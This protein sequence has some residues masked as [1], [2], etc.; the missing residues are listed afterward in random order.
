MA[1]VIPKDSC[2][3]PLVQQKYCCVPAC[4]LM[5]MQ[6][7]GLKLVSQE[8]LGYHLGLIIP[9]EDSYLF[10]NARTG[11]RPRA[12]YGTQIYKKEF[13]PNTVFPKLDI[14]L[15]MTYKPIDDVSDLRDFKNYLMTITGD[16]DV[17]VCFDYG[18]L[19]N[20]DY[21][22]GHVCIVDKVDVNNN[23]IR[24]IDPSRNQS[25]W[26]IVN[27]EKLKLAMERHGVEKS[28]GFWEFEK[29]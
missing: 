14:P 21:H 19:F 27:I 17:V 15:K 26:R 11:E 5:I 25:K 1:D 16:K 28:G 22:L 20:T 3:F 8:E 10:W 13:H 23:K 6:R 4:I 24:L 7:H 12:G 2:Y 9:K 18:T 29:L